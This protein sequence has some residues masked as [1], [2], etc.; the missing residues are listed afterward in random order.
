MPF[1]G[2]SPIGIAAL[3]AIAGG[4]VL[5]V[6]YAVGRGLVHRELE[7]ID[8]VGDTGTVAPSAAAAPP[9]RSRTLGALGAALLVAGLALGV[10]S[11]IGSWDTN[12]ATSG[13]G[14]APGDCA[15][16]WEGCPKATPNP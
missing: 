14:T 16:S 3:I 2:W 8:S 6:A 4:I 15:Q 1:A 5:L 7:G 9:R 10:A 13:P 12:Q 11:A